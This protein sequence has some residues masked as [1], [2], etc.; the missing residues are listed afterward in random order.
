MNIRAFCGY[1]FERHV[2]ILKSLSSA[3]ASAAASATVTAAIVIRGFCGR[4]E[5]VNRESYI[6][7]E[8]ARLA[9]GC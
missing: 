6:I 3:A 1:A 4:K 2:F 8:I 9:F 7:K 5:F